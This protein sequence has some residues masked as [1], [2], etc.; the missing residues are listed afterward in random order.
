MMRRIQNQL[1]ET[2]MFLLLVIVIFPFTLHAQMTARGLGMGGAYTAVARGVHAADYNPANL[3]LPDNVK[4]SM[5]II[6]AEAGIWNNAFNKEMYDKYLVEGADPETNQI[7]WDENDVEN[8]LD[9]IPNDGLNMFTNTSVKGFSFSAGRFA[10]SIRG[11]GNSF[12]S[13]DKTA[14]EI[15]L[16]GTKIGKTYSF[17]NTDGKGIGV[18]LVSFSWGQPMKVSFADHFA[19]GSTIHLIYGGGYAQTD[20]A[21]FTIDNMVYGVNLNG[22]YKATYALGNLGW[23]LDVGAAAQMGKKWTLGASLSQLLGSIPWSKDMKVVEGFIKGDS[24][25]VEN[26]LDEEEDFDD[27]ERDIAAFS[28][29]LPVVLRV[30]CSYKEGDVLLAADYYQSFKESAWANTTPRISIGTEWQKVRWLPLRMGVI[31][32]GRMGF[33]TSFGL[34]LRLG[35]FV[36]DLG[37]MNQGFISPNNS[38]GMI[39]A[40]GMGIDMQRKS[41]GSTKVSDFIHS[42]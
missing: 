1:I 2:T 35:S 23:G 26:E 38:K 19:F 5:T 33:G 29:K 7:Y 11:T 37:V 3:G 39:L 14:F 8:I 41:N 31:L 27:D 30:G 34:G 15:P 25:N 40:I 9:A 13:L 10:F 16:A 17:N 42:P 4:F 32:G 28:T 12:L 24:I 6:S 20:Y 21:N 36:V 22:D 18:G